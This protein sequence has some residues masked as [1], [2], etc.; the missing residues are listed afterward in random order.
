MQS[1]TLIT[2]KAI[3]GKGQGALLLNPVRS[4]VTGKLL[5][6]KELSEEER[7]K[8]VRPIT[9]DT[10]RRISDGLT[11]DLSNPVDAIDWEWIKYNEEI[12]DSFD[13]AQM[14]PKALF[15]IDK[16]DQEVE[17]RLKRGE[18]RFEAESFIRNCSNKKL[19]EVARYLGQNIN[20]MKPSD[21]LDWLLQRITTKNGPEEILKAR[22]DKKFSRRLFLFDLIENKK[23]KRD[24]NDIHYYGDIVMGLNRT[25]TIEWLDN[26]K[27]ADIVGKLMAELYGEEE[28]NDVPATKKSKNS[29]NTGNTGEV[30]NDSQA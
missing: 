29:K 16:P 26:P 4:R 20:Y 24:S 27:N 7:R 30:D 13:E 14:S 12:A 5:G 9:A 18:M 11:I 21:I 8:E 17:D 10:Q 23:V 22:D 25:A 28:E 15:Y 2:L 3:Y 1:E 19:Q 6:V